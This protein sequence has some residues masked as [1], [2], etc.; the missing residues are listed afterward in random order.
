MALYC[1]LVHARAGSA[2]ITLFPDFAEIIS[3]A[4]SV[5]PD[6]Q[7]G[8]AFEAIAEGV[9]ALYAAEMRELN[10]AFACLPNHA[11][12][13]RKALLQR[14]P[15]IV[16]YQ[17]DDQIDSF[18]QDAAVCEARGFM[19]P[20][21]GSHAI[22]ISGHA[23]LILGYDF[24]VQAFIARNSWG[25]ALGRGRAFSHPVRFP[26]GL[27]R[28]HRYLGAPPRRA[29]GGVSPAERNDGGEALP[30]RFLSRG[31]ANPCPF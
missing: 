1:S 6:R 10:A 13:L 31:G 29:R 18:H 23:V 5:S 9:Q 2:D 7:R 11:P 8:V 22:S 21:F 20:Y 26:G 14:S 28:V 30:A 3:R 27:V 4:L 17:V 19:L 12:A 16:G 24:R 15:V 25:G